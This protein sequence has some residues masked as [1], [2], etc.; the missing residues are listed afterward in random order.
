MMSTFR[1]HMLPPKYKDA[2]FALVKTWTSI[3][4]PFASITTPACIGLFFE[5]PRPLVRQAFK[6]ARATS[7]PNAG[8]D[9]LWKC[10]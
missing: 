8:F 10:H 9:D 3:Q 1:Q 7:Y 5:Q 4:E 2:E 6:P